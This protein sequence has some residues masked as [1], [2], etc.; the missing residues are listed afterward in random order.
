MVCGRRNFG[1]SLAS[2][3]AVAVAL[4]VGAWLLCATRLLVVFC[5]CVKFR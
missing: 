1:H 4:G 3:L 5:L 2:G